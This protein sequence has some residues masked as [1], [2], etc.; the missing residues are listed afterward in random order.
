MRR[1]CYEGPKSLPHDTSTPVVKCRQTSCR[2]VWFSAA[3]GKSPLGVL[4]TQMRDY[5]IF[6]GFCSNRV[7]KGDIAR[8]L[9]S[10]RHGNRC[11]AWNGLVYL[12]YAMDCSPWFISSTGES[13]TS[14]LLE[15]QSM[16]GFGFLWLLQAAHKECLRP[17]F[18]THTA[19][20]STGIRRG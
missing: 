9:W 12:L 17:R 18:D 7:G 16:Y 10:A 4:I 13:T 1:H 5:S 20:N 6:G 8:R 3:P 2:P 14:C 11:H 19:Q 15:A